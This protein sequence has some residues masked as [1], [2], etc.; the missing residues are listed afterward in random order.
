MIADTPDNWPVFQRGLNREEKWANRN[1]VKFNKGSEKSCTYTVQTKCQQ[2]GKEL[3]R[4]GP[5]P[6]MCIDTKVNSPWATVEELLAG[7][8]R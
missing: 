3:V 2:E 4:S 1:F 6:A 8:G 7:Q 5:E